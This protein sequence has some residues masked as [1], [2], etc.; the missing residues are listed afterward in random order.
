MKNIPESEIF[1]KRPFPF[2]YITTNDP[3]DLTY[4]K[5]YADLSDMK[6]KGYGGIVPFNRP[7]HGFT[8]EQYFTEEWFSMMDNC[9]RACHDVGLKVWINDDYDCPPGDIGGRLEKIAPHLRPLRIRLDGEN[10]IVEEVSWGFPAFEHPESPLYFQRIVYEE[11]KRRYGKYF[12][13][14]I[15]GMF[16]DADSRRVN[17]YVYDRNSPM[18][19]YFPWTDTF[20]ETFEKAYGY[21]ITPY[22]P[23]IIRREESSQSRDYWEHNNI[24]YMNWFAS[25]YEWCKNNGLE[26]TFH[27]SDT[28][29]WPVSTSYFCSAFSEGKAIDAGVRCDWPGTDHEEFGLSSAPWIRRDLFA[30]NHSVAYEEKEEYRRSNFFDTYSDLRAKQAQSSAFLYDKRGVMCEMFAGTSWSAS[31]KDLRNIAT[32]QFMQGVTFVVYQAYHI[33][34]WKE[35]KDFAPLTFGPHSHTNFNLREFNDWIAETAYVCEQGKLK[36]DVAILDPTDEIW[37]N[38]GDSKLYLDLAKR[39]NNVPNGHI[40]SDM[41]GIRRKASQLKAVI[42]PGLSLTDEQRAEISSLG[43]KLYEYEDADKIVKDIPCGISWN[44]EGKLMFMRREL[45]DG[46]E[47]LI[48]ANVESDDTLCG[49]LTFDGKEYE[50]ELTSGEMAFFGGGF[51]KYRTPC[52]DEIKLPL[53]NVAKVSFEKKNMLSLVRFENDE[54]KTVTLR[55]PH[56]NVDWTIGA[57]WLPKDIDVVEENPTKTP[58]FRFKA[59]TAL[60]D[61][62]LLIPDCMM[63]FIDD[64]QVDGKKLISDTAVKV[65]DDD[66]RSFAFDVDAGEHEILVA[67]NDFVKSP[68][69]MYLRGDFDSQVD[70]SGELLYGYPDLVREYADVTL[71]ERRKSLEMGLSWTRQ[72]QTTYSGSAIYTVSVNIPENIKNPTLVIPYNHDP[73]KVYVDGKLVKNL[74]T[75]PFRAQLGDISGEHE[76]ML[77]VTNTLGNMLKATC[78]PSGI[79]S[80]PYITEGN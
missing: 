60:S 22:L 17:C 45:E 11:Y 25:N 16:S 15:I 35:T 56:T 28:A 49:T 54:R 10:V 67:I 80:I 52:H 78:V 58:V 4:E 33:K 48:V 6:E 38:R 43:L 79:I 57:G 70:V 68:S 26:Y 2:Y 40:L 13:N 72:G 19:D 39:F 31:L 50:I 76:I 64:I 32:W 47:F 5:F 3:K 9:I 63:M 7:P 53:P 20:A 41:K 71:S 14:T 36:V 61:L 51:D 34:L 23:S 44:G 69:I 46:K 29:P 37:A 21:D 8:R 18:I 24:L 75:A 62:E 74:A 65:L 12:G 77:E 30:R 73:I 1:K 66:Y 59:D 55:H 27:T 42:N